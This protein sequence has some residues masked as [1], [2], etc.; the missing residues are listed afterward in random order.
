MKALTIKQPWASLI[1]AGIKDVENR[2]WPTL[3]RGPL[4]IH[5]GM[6]VDLEALDEWWNAVPQPVPQGR[7]VA[8]VELVACVRKVRS[9]WVNRD[10]EWHWI[11][12]DPQPVRGAP[13]VRGRQRLF[14][15]TPVGRERVTSR[16]W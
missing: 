13:Q 14:E 7:V 10:F 3:Y 11:L 1:A 6:G 8:R 4:L 5:A 15:L 12:R 2:S 16:G 9:R